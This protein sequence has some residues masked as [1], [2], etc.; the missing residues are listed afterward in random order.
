MYNYK[1]FFFINA[2]K[3]F[4]ALFPNGSFNFKQFSL[5][6]SGLIYSLH[7]ASSGRS[8]V[9]EIVSC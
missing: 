2:K 8:A 1:D 6:Y 4:Y 7:K 5:C 9:G 3:I